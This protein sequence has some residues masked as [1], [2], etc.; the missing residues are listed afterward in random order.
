MFGG[1]IMSYLR[2]IDS[3]F[4]INNVSMPKPHGVVV[5][6]KWNNLDADRD[7]NTGAMILNPVNRIYEVT[8]KYKL[9]R[10]DQYDIL[11]GQVFQASKSA[12]NNKAFKTYDPNRRTSITFTTYEP[13]DFTPPE[14]AFIRDGYKYFDTFE[15]HFT[16]IAGVTET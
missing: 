3:R 5:K 8:W 16:S 10:S 12:Y 13:D 1:I 9:L 6:R 11:M 2:D 14:V 4:T 15:L 7:I